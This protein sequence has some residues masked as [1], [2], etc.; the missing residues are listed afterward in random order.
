ML[1]LQLPQQKVQKQSYLDLDLH[2]TPTGT[3]ESLSFEILIEPL[4]KTLDASVARILVEILNTAKTSQNS[5][6]KSWS[7]IGLARI[8]R[9]KHKIISRV[10][11]VENWHT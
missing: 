6:R 1:H 7:R 8:R 9:I 4:Q 3:P 10:V 5:V 11:V 2:C